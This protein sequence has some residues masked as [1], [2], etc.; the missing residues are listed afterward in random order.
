MAMV[1]R[2]E[3][4]VEYREVRQSRWRARG[5]GRVPVNMRIQFEFSSAQEFKRGY[6]RAPLDMK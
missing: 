1:G 2:D 3:G 4:S 5:R 6:N